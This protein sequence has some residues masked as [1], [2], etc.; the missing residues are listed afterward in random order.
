MIELSF[1]QGLKGSNRLK[2]QMMIS[3]FKYEHEKIGMNLLTTQLV[4]GYDE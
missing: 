4:T 2:K 1:I 3:I